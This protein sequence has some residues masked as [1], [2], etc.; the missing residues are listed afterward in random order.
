MILTK[1]DTDFAKYY[2]SGLNVPLNFMFIFYLNE[3]SN[4]VDFKRLIDR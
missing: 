3:K 4:A 2:K 1:A